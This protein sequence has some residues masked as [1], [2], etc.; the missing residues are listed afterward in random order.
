MPWIIIRFSLFVSRDATPNMF[1]AQ[2]VKEV[3]QVNNTD[4]PEQVLDQH[5]DAK[6]DAIKP[7]ILR[8]RTKKVRY[9]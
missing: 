5:A 3:K 8:E 7:R 1:L 6:V 2:L 9:T 4:T